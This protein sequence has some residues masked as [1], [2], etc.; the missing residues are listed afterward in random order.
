MS[1]RRDP[2]TQGA[3]IELFT[4][5]LQSVIATI[6]EMGGNGVVVEIEEPNPGQGTRIVTAFFPW[7]SIHHVRMLTK[8]AR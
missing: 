1:E 5:D 3:I 2:F 6:I 4:A 7:T 8:R